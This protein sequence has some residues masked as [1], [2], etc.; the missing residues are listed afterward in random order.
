MWKLLAERVAERSL[1]RV[2]PENRETPQSVVVR[3]WRREYHART[4]AK[5]SP[6]GGSSFKSGLKTGAERFLSQVVVHALE[7]NWRSPEDFFRHF[8]P[9]DLMQSLEAAPDLRKDILVLAAGVHEKIARKKSTE[10]AAE[11]LKIALDEEVTTPPDLLSLIQPDDRVR[12]LDRQRLWTFTFE[13]EFYAPLNAEANRERAIERMAFLLETAIE[14]NL[15]SLQEIADGITFATIASRLPQRE[16][17]KV[18]EHTLTIG[19]NG[20]ALTEEVLLELV[21]LRTLLGYIPL[22][23]VWEKVIAARIGGPGQLLGGARPAKPSTSKP[24]KSSPASDVEASLLSPKDEFR[25]SPPPKP[26]AVGL[27]P[28]NGGPSEPEQDVDEL[29][30]T[31]SPSNAPPGS[32][33][34]EARGKVVERLQGID[35]LPPRHAELTTAMLLSIESM[36][37]ELL[38]A[39]TDDV[40]EEAIR[41]S[42][43]NE[44]HLT[45]ALLALIEL[46]DPSIDTK[47]PVIRD[48]DIDSLIKVVL[49]EERNRYEQAHPSQRPPGNPSPP[50][51]PP[52]RRSAPPPLPKGPPPLADKPR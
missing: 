23:L 35:R 39:S 14:E 33:E 6:S 32:P 2:F 49:F 18:L 12:Y 8:Q 52:G 44:Q 51:L 37:S 15:L 10:S 27:S 29:F 13:D 50:P 36:Y 7:D 41:D 31:G 48:A 47:D 20:S 16:L 19:R 21:P 25:G 24:K 46:L 40:R 5:H 11:D 1:G 34:E 30:E 3:T 38:S 4:M 42:F 28:S 22:D 26:T 43:P 17:Q 9:L 45:T